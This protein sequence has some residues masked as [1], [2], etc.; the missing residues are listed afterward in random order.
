MQNI[1]RCKAQHP[2]YLVF[3]EVSALLFKAEATETVIL[4]TA[5]LETNVAFFSKLRASAPDQFQEP[6]FDSLKDIQLRPEHK[7]NGTKVKTVVVHMNHCKVNVM[8]SSRVELV[9][10]RESHLKL[11]TEK[12]QC[13]TEAQVR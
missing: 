10:V 11:N 8:S 7:T 1:S 9:G 12:K 6:A 2:S 4:W 3:R 5:F 13:C